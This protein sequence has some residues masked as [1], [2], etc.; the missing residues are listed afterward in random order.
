MGDEY[1]R[2]CKKCE[3][4][5]VAHAFSNGECNICEKEIQTSHIPC[6]KVCRDCSVEKNVCM[7]CKS[8]F[9]KEE[10]EKFASLELDEHIGDL[11]SKGSMDEAMELLTG[12]FTVTEYLT[13]EEIISKYGT[14]MLLK[15]S[16]PQLETISNYIDHIIEEK[17][18]LESLVHAYRWKMKDKLDKAFAKV[19]E[20]KDGSV[21]TDPISEQEMQEFCDSIFEPLAEFDRHFKI[22]T[23][24]KGN[25]NK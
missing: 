2:Y 9:S 24:R 17:Q 19:M 12:G 16:G 10:L 14:E 15:N 3:G 4:M 21:W 5:V 25:T 8:P 6:D 20:M 22:T 18:Q 23:E 1:N 13:T 11:V 7:S